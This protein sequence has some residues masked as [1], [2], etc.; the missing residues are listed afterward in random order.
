[1]V[2]ELLI[3]TIM[4]SSVSKTTFDAY[5]RTGE[6]QQ[7]GHIELLLTLAYNNLGLTYYELSMQAEYNECMMRLNDV[8]GSQ[9][10]LFDF[11]RSSC[12]D[13]VIE[14]I[15]LNAIYW[16]SFLPSP[17]ALAA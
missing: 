10:G 8:F 14:E 5:K 9:N 15:K 2:I 1:V 4:T 11:I 3:H 13:D 6:V 12:F 17:I 16:K 7:L